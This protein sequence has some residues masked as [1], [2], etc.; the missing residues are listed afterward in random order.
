MKPNH[1]QLNALDNPLQGSASI[2]TSATNS[3][4]IRIDYAPTADEV[5]RRV[6]LS[7]GNQSWLPGDE[8]QRWLKAEEQ[9]LAERD[10]AQVYDTSERPQLQMSR[11]THHERINL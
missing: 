11:T 10:V 3:N 5:A 8:L 6:Y 7:Y 9:L 4:H 2:A 1:K